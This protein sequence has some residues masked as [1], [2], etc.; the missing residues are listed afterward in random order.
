[1]SLSEMMRLRSLIDQRLKEIDQY[2]RGQLKVRARILAEEK[3]A[4]WFFR[5]FNRKK[6]IDQI[7]LE[8]ESHV[9]L[10]CYTMRL[11]EELQLTKLRSAIDFSTKHSIHFNPTINDLSVLYKD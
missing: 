10:M 1:M 4:S 5:F 2:R 6:T 9:V 8:L 11:E 3:M 7:A